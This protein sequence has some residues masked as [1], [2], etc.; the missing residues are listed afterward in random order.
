MEK[1]IRM[2]ELI[3]LIN[4]ANA[5]YYS[6]KKE[7]MPNHEWDK[8]YEELLELEKTTGI[9]LS[10]SPTQN[11]GYEAVS[12]LPKAE[13]EQPA[14]SLDKTKEMEQ[15]QDFQGD[16]GA[17]LSWKLDGLTV[18]LTYKDGKL[19][20]A[21]TR[22]NGLVGEVIT[23]NAKNFVNVPL[24]I[25][26]AGDMTVR[27]EAII[28]YEDFERINAS[29]PEGE[30][31]YKNPRNLC[32]GSVR[33]LDSA[34][35]K[36][37]N[38]RFK[39][40][41][42]AKSPTTPIMTRIMSRMTQLNILELA[43]F[44][45]VEHIYV[46][47]SQELPK[48]VA[49]FEAR[50]QYNPFPSDGLVL[51]L[52]DIAY[53]ESLGITSK[54]P[55]DAMAFKWQDEEKDT[56]VKELVWSASRT[57]LLIPVAVFEPVELEGTTVTRASVHNV[58]MVK[59]LQICPGD[60]VSVY[61]ANMIIPQIAENQTRNGEPDI[62]KYCPVCGQPTQIRTIASDAESLWCINPDCAAKHIGRFTHAVSRD[63]LN[64]D[65]LSEK[66]LR[67]LIEAGILSE[68]ADLFR[69]KEQK[70]IITRM[71]GM[72]EKSYEKLVKAVEKARDTDLQRL[73]YALGI[74]NIG[75]TA[76]K[77]ICRYYQ[78]D[79]NKILGATKEELQ[80]I[81]DIGE[82]VATS[83]ITW[84]ANQ[85]NQ[86]TFELLLWELRLKKPQMAGPMPLAGKT[87][88]ITGA[89]H[90]FRNREEL[91]IRI[92][93]MG[94]KV[95]GSVSSKTTFLINNDKLS[96]TGKNKKAKELGIPVIDE[97]TLLGMMEG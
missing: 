50:I 2:E 27:G 97:E 45:V 68:L 91:K 78:Y 39:A 30:E 48:R 37:R 33:Q 84:F 72:G 10:S 36:K 13:H 11:V 42:M 65:G 43:G 75:R 64:I 60:T 20:K 16:H 57:G 40:F 22:G 86:E 1:K 54:Y 15:L 49:Q 41:A 61:K 69:L 17:V 7:L 71:E 67:K 12:K 83:F 21:V 62:P 34:E 81:P 53:G 6:G 38:V 3:G 24:Q 92:E 55:R 58:S 52:D 73:L 31:P 96:T 14:L 35:T 93:S 32:A 76:S 77:L 66:T 82:V 56:T 95:S 47:S 19:E 74:E 80:K 25:P 63:A 29:L 79:M 5:A 28:T 85:K 44:D 87:F 4:E 70:S 26:V 94:G 23:E 8:L 59:A 18:V 46:E 51:Q 88:V 89:V 9:I 90:H